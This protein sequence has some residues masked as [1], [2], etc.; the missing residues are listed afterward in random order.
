MDAIIPYL[1]WVHHLL[2]T[3]MTIK[4]C[5]QQ[6]ETCLYQ[7]HMAPLSYPNIF[8]SRKELKL[9]KS[10]QV[11]L[12]KKKYFFHVTDKKF[13]LQLDYH[14]VNNISVDAIRKLAGMVITEHVFIYRKKFYKQITGGAIESAFTLTLANIF[15]WKLE[16]ELVRRQ[17][18]SNDIYDRY[19]PFIVK[20]YYPRWKILAIK[21][22]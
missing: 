15:M 10:V 13:L 18:V 14:K 4:Q 9:M 6:L 3:S 19:V 16:R 11:R 12:K 1:S 20:E 7:Q 8:S 21:I 5:S 22:D 2:N 17:K